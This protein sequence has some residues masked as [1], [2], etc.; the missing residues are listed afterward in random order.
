MRSNIASN[1]AKLFGVGRMTAF[2]VGPRIVLFSLPYLALM[3]VLHVRWPGIFLMT[4]NFH[5]AFVV[6]GG[7]LIAFGIGLWASG[8]KVIDRAF[9]EGRLLTT[10]VYGLVR[11]PMY[12]GIL[13]FVIP[14][15]ALALRSWP[16]ITIPLVMYLVFRILIKEEDAYL[17]EVFGLEYVDYR[18]RVNAVVPIPRF[19]GSR[20]R[21]A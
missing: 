1:R 4:A 19:F 10:G 12:S 7:V 11:H 2:G 17:T 9:K 5:V 3:V 20:K 15:V 18:N 6:V 16:L 8:A 21:A 13:L 14:G